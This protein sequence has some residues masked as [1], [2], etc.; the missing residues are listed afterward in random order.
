MFFVGAAISVV[1]LWAHHPAITLIGVGIMSF[2]LINE[3]ERQTSD[4]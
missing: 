4:N 3:N 2:W 1:G